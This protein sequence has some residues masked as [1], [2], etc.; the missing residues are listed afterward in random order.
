KKNKTTKAEELSPHTFVSG[1]WK[2][3]LIYDGQYQRTWIGSYDMSNLKYVALYNAA[4]GN[5]T[6]I[7]EDEYMLVREVENNK[8]DMM[9]LDKGNI[10]RT[11]FGTYD[12]TKLDYPVLN[13]DKSNTGTVVNGQPVL[14]ITKI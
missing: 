14:I 13:D 2:M 1:K 6:I 3:V 5:V 8:F 12:L 11:W 4:D 7:N 9:Y 10:R